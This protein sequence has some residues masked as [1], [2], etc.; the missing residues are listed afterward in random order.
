[1]KLAI[2]NETHSFFANQDMERGATQRGDFLDE[3]IPLVATIL[4]SVFPT[5]LDSLFLEAFF[6]F[7]R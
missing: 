6:S 2:H 5:S 4:K 3:G 7:V 1:M